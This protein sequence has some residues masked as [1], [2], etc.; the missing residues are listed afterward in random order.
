MKT[1]RKDF[2]EFKRNCLKWQNKLG[3]TNWSIYFEHCPAKGTYAKTHWNTVQ[4]AATIQFATYWDS[5][6][7]KNS[8]EIDKLALH[9]VVHVL[10]APLV[11]EA[12]YRYT[13]LDAIESAE[14]SIVRSLE[15]LILTICLVPKTP[16]R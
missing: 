2:E 12:E 14:H 6:R 1:T 3:I 5:T 15:N 10:L 13:S 8:Y 11:S 4:M 16:K 9:E 7:P